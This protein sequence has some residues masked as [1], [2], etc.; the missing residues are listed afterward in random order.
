MTAVS[1][2][3]EA[4]RSRYKNKKSSGSSSTGRKASTL[5]IIAGRWKRRRLIIP[6]VPG[7][8]PTPDRVRETL[9]NWLGH[10]IHGARCLDLFAGTGALGFEAASRGAAE[11]VL[12]ERNEIAIREIEAGMRALSVDR[13]DAPNTPKITVVHADALRY[14]Q[15]PARCFD[16]VFLD[17]PFDSDLLETVCQYLEDGR[18]LGETAEIYLEMRRSSHQ[19]VL[20]A[21]WQEARSAVAGEV[22]YALM[23]RTVAT[24]KNRVHEKHE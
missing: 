2:T 14:L 3:K 21:S 8:R 17:P 24:T 18:W 19:P 5:R 12:V 11:V 10:R 22:K 20:P 9:F 13:E 1:E 15:G 6:D 4:I 23:Q 16:M 7:L